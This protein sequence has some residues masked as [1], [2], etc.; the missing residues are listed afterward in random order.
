VMLSPGVGF[1]GGRG[2]LGTIG[3]ILILGSA[4]GG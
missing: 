1:S 4:S 3:Y 2:P